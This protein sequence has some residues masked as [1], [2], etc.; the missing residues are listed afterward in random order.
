MEL[1]KPEIAM[2]DRLFEA[3]LKLFA[4]KGYHATSVREIVEAAGVSKPVL[5]YWFRNK[6]GVFRHLM[7]EAVAAH[8][9]ILA[10]VQAEGGPASER[11]LLLGER[12]MA[13]VVE[14]KEAVR[15]LDSVHYGP[16]DGAPAVD[17]GALHGE[18]DAALRELVAEAL[19]SGEFRDAGVE[20]MHHALLGAFFICKVMIHEPTA[21]GCDACGPMGLQDVRRIMRV[22]M[23]GM[24]AD[25]PRSGG[26]R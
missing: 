15:V 10:E 3:A 25:R 2:R 23:D 4:R 11:I 17:F 22:V 16:I 19:A 14:N 6:E 1:Q 24:W 9:Q 18:F 12:V 21:A 26:E 8:R 5:Y 7:D 20:D 13:L